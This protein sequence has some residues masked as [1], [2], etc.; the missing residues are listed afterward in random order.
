VIGCFT[1][2]LV[3]A[4]EYGKKMADKEYP[5]TVLLCHVCGLSSL[6]LQEGGK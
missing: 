6:C 4:D 2:D 3:Y 1:K 5:F